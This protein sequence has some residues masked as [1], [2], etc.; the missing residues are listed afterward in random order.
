METTTMMLM[1]VVTSRAPS[2]LPHL[3]PISMLRCKRFQNINYAPF[4]T[5]CCLKLAYYPFYYQRKFISI[6]SLVAPIHQ[7]GL[8]VASLCTLWSRATGIVQ[9]VQGWRLISFMVTWKALW[10]KMPIIFNPFRKLSYVHF[11]EVFLP[12]KYAVE[13]KHWGLIMSILHWISV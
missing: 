9:L 8:C 12:L 11:K 5:K 4:N 7:N 13:W 2:G 1:C 6:T 3:R 10:K